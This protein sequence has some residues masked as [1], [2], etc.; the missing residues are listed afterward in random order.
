MYRISIPTSWQPQLEQQ[1]QEPYF[2]QLM[3][4]L[5]QRAALGKTIFPPQ[6]QVFASLEATAFE[7]VRVVIIGQDP[8]HGENQAN[9]LSFS[10]N[11]EQSKLPPSLKNIYKALDKDLAI[12]VAEHGDLSSWAK[13]GV[14]LLNSVLTVEQA[15]ANSHANQGWEQFTDAVITSLNQ[16][17]TPIVFLLWGKYAQKKGELITNDAHKVLKSVHPSPLSAH[18]GFFDCQH[19]SKAN[20]ILVQSGQAPIQWSLID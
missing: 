20:Q 17:K 3:L 7:Q 14:L 12:P 16:T 8:Y 13:Q 15:D 10:V 6:D 9:G 4:F 11:R 5:Q 1:L 19:F 18:R 2:K